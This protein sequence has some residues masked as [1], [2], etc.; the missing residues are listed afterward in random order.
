MRQYKKLLRLDPQDIKLQLEIADVHRRWDQ[1]GEAR[2][3]YERIAGHYMEE[4]FDA[5]AVAVYKQ[6]LSLAPNSDEAHTRLAELYERMGLIAEAL[7]SL[8]VAADALKQRGER[9]EALGLLRRM[10]ALDPG[11]TAS[12]LKVANLLRQEGMDVEALME[13]E[14]LIADL[15]RQEDFERAAEVCHS[16]LKID[17]DR[18]STRFALARNLVGQR[19]FAE[20][21]EPARRG[22]E[23]DPDTAENY[24]VLI[25]ALR[26]A[27]LEDEVPDVYSRLAD[28][29][30]RRG[31]EDRAREIMQR[32]LS[33]SSLD[34]GVEL[35]S[36]PVLGAEAAQL[37]GDLP[38]I[39]QSTELAPASPE[40]PGPA[41]WPVSDEAQESVVDFPSLRE[42]LPETDGMPVEDAAP[43]EA[44][45]LLDFEEAVAEAA[46]LLGTQEYA[47]ALERLER[48][49]DVEAGHITALE[50]LGEVR[51]AMGEPA[52]AVEAWQR[53]SK[54]ARE[55]GDD[56]HSG[57]L[58]ARIDGVGGRA[59]A[60]GGAADPPAASEL[61]PPL[62]AIEIELDLGGQMPD[63]EFDEDPTPVLDRAQESLFPPGDSD[64]ALS[65]ALEEA[66]F[67]FRQGLN[68]EAKAIYREILDRDPG[69]AT[70]RSRLAELANPQPDAV[71]EAEAPDAPDLVPQELPG[72][73]A[74]VPESG[75]FD[76]AAE[77]SDVLDDS[78]SEIAPQTGGDDGFATVFDA[79][80][81]GV[82]ETLAEGDYQA[83]Y[84]LGIAYKE[85]GLFPDA[86]EEFRSAMAEPGRRLECLHLIGLCALDAG[87]AGEAVEKLEALLGEPDL[88]SELVLSLRFDLGRALAALGLPDRAREAFE[89]VAAIDPAF[90]DVRAQIEA[91]PSPPA[92]SLEEP[93]E[94]DFE[95]F[96]DLFAEDF[97]EGPEAVAEEPEAAAAPELLPAEPGPDSKPDPEAGAAPV[98]TR[99]KKISFA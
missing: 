66:D 53:A 32:H 88:Q 70:A 90:Q 1:I 11:N 41:T 63:L 46:V 99:K 38:S 57:A 62:D 86:V 60:G 98:R 59:V 13:F 52:L 56:E 71:V 73:D 89:A 83:H 7:N 2:E 37:D 17:A 20:A 26:G 69:H 94:E 14:V 78:F 72:V 42:P 4:G 67:Y 58:Q 39:L 77:L 5:R 61:A 92:V 93:A 43:R 36:D 31:D 28:L 45:P 34:L 23:L 74:S 65:E 15:E 6:I 55:E 48:V 16:A 80:K 24:D 75:A 47:Q 95:N 40:I 19:L 18:A 91:L 33:P 64:R 8:K 50:T 22:L 97:G 35:A 54:R 25:E 84:D 82:G 51:L 29:H 10:A 21:V 12:R 49:L 44:L 9:V 68:G 30:R 79:F 76:L 96:D 85:M 3:T 81:K 27:G 87:D